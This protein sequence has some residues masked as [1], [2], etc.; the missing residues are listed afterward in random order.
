MEEG[1][2]IRSIILSLNESEKCKKIED[3]STYKIYYIHFQVRGQAVEK[4][5][6]SFNT[7]RYQRAW[8]IK[9]ITK[10]YAKKEKVYPKN[11]SYPLP[12][13][14][15]IFKYHQNHGSRTIRKHRAAY[16]EKTRTS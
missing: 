13:P 15:Q 12:Y 14:L 2:E 7:P 4:R 9:M 5:F 11:R 10:F 3:L 1:E 16:F 8:Q 6:R